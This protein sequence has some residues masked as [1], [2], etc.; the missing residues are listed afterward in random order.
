MI[1]SPSCPDHFCIRD[2]LAAYQHRVNVDIFRLILRSIK[3]FK[4][5]LAAPC[6]RIRLHLRKCASGTIHLFWPTGMLILENR[7]GKFIW[8][9]LVESPYASRTQLWL[10]LGAH[11]TFSASGALELRDGGPLWYAHRGPSQHWTPV[12]NRKRKE[13]LMCM[14]TPQ[15]LM[16][17]KW[18]PLLLFFFF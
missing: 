13:M 6:S 7:K 16:D 8:L 17:L 12:N 11:V 4:S 18:S 14:E 10:I 3:R 2:D 9:P 1:P 15:L 5:N